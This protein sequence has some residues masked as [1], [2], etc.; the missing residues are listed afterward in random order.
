MTNEP[1]LYFY[2]GAGALILWGKAG[3]TWSRGLLSFRCTQTLH[4]RLCTNGDRAARVRGVWSLCRCWDCTAQHRSAGSGRRAGMD[5][6]GV[7]RIGADMKSWLRN[8]RVYQTIMNGALLV[9][10]LA[11]LSTGKWPQLGWVA[12]SITVIM[13]LVVA[14][15][16]SIAACGSDKEENHA[17]DQVS[18]PP[19]KEELAESTELQA[20]EL[21]QK[22]LLQEQRLFRRLLQERLTAEALAR[23]AH[24]QY[25]MIYSNWLEAMRQDTTQETAAKN[26]I[27]GNMLVHKSRTRAVRKRAAETVSFTE[28]ATDLLVV[29]VGSVRIE[30]HEQETKVH[31][32]SPKTTVVTGATDT[33][34]TAS[35]KKEPLTIARTEPSTISR[36]VH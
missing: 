36:T 28:E 4:E 20:R 22:R 6:L 2:A 13:V 9:V 23:D 3:Q 14:A 33:G 10:F 32:T 35:D 25:Q 19:K 27:L 8:D 16:Y 11:A 31:I 15:V 18:T 7:Q 5:G 30:I 12:G 17:R 26:L 21:L 34:D 1:M 29:T 24:K